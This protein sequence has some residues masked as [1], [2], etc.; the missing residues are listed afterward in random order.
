MVAVLISTIIMTLQLM[1][2]HNNKIKINNQME[3]TTTVKTSNRI[4]KSKD[5]RTTNPELKNMY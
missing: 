1:S 2:S 5:V 4:S 3:I